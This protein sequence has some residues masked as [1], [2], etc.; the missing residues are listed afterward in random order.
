MYK[1]FGL[2]R[3]IEITFSAKHINVFS[4]FYFVIFF[5]L[6]FIRFKFFFFLFICLRLRLIDFK[7]QLNKSKRESLKRIKVKP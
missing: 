2:N 3:S 6:I 5:Q 7:T 4:G 1:V